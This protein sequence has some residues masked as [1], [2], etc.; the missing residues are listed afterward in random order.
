MSDLT[1]TGVKIMLDEER[2]L[3]FSLN[4]MS[5]AVD[6]FGKM[7]NILNDSAN[8][9]EVAKWLAV[10][11]INEGIEIWNDKHPD[12]KKE[13]IEERKL[14]RYVVGLGGYQVLQEKVQEAIL[15]G[16]PDNKVKEVEEMGKNLIAVQSMNREQRRKMK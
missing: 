16:L 9:L 3:V 5:D 13:L 4:V 15:K 12:R 2:E 11:M 8:N 10:Q 6:K 7:D 1:N 14:C